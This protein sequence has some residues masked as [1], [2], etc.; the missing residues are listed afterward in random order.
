MRRLCAI[1]KQLLKPGGTVIIFC[2]E[3]QYG[4]YWEYFHNT[5]LELEY[6]PLYVT[7][8]YDIKKIRV[9]TMHFRNMAMEAIV[10]HKKNENHTWL[11]KVKDNVI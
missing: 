5:N 8:A 3:I 4:K 6:N 1:S 11:W 7:Y 9:S 10:A 2:S